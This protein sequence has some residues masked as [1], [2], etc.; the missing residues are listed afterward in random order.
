MKLEVTEDISILPGLEIL[1][2]SQGE[3]DFCTDWCS[4]H[5]HF[6]WLLL[7]ITFVSTIAKPFGQPFPAPVLYHEQVPNTPPIWHRQPGKGT[8][9]AV[10][11]SR[12]L[13]HNL[14]TRML[15]VFTSWAAFHKLQCHHVP[16]P[17]LRASVLTPDEHTLLGV[18]HPSACPAME[19]AQFL[20]LHISR[21]T[22]P[23]EMLHYSRMLSE[24]H[25][26]IARKSL[27]ELF[28]GTIFFG[29]E[30]SFLPFLC[31][32]LEAAFLWTSRDC[33]LAWGH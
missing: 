13:I 21:L 12:E 22:M 27:P 11:T 31:P 10:S 15:S 18:L 19:I 6:Q 8:R 2:V 14:H 32:V 26:A 33:P 16:T 5:F 1:I 20:L 3:P 4:V 7:P 29:A 24:S 9:A 25:R 28:T 17:P 30:G 23:S